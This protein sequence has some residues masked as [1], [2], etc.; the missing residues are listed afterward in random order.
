MNE[1]IGILTGFLSNLSPVLLVAVLALSVAGLS[2]YALYRVA[3][4]LAEKVHVQKIE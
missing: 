2:V 4:I 3:L 1:I